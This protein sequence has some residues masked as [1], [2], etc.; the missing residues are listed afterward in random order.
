[1]L[2]AEQKPSFK[3]YSRK[4]IKDFLISAAIKLSWS[5]FNQPRPYQRTNRTICRSLNFKQSYWFQHGK[6]S[7]DTGRI[8][9][10][11]LQS[12]EFCWYRLRATKKTPNNIAAG[13]GSKERK[14]NLEKVHNQPSQGVLVCLRVR[15]NPAVWE[16]LPSWKFPGASSPS[17]NFLISGFLIPM[18]HSKE[19][20]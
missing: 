15:T 8:F 7:H 4:E 3:Q 20:D 5:H 6:S 13:R 1:M 11:Q 9:K 14:H 2:C 12:L 19:E 18:F 16:H 17:I 10:Y